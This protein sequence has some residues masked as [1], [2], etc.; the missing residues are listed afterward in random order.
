MPDEPTEKLE[1]LEGKA[2]DTAIKTTIVSTGDMKSLEETLKDP[3]IKQTKKEE[4]KRYAGKHLGELA[5][6]RRNQA[7]RALHP[8]VNEL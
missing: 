5:R 4:I 6:Q 7:K 1:N 2:L 3:N 8:K